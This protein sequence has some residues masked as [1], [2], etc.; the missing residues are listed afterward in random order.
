M[1][2]RNFAI[3]LLAK[4]AIMTKDSNINRQVLEHDWVLGHLPTKLIF[5]VHFLQILWKLREISLTGLSFSSAVHGWCVVRGAR[6]PTD[7]WLL[8]PAPEP[9][10]EEPHLAR[11]GDVTRHTSHTG[12]R[13]TWHVAPTLH[14]GTRHTWLEGS[15]HVCRVTRSGWRVVRIEDGCQGRGRGDMINYERNRWPGSR[16]EI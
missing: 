10:T 9:G 8:P 4:S 6:R 14:T 2:Q 12:T 3:F 1:Y 13:V 5:D 11:P 7:S 16:P 15:C